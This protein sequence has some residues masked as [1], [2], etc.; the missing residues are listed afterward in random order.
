MAEALV[1]PRRFTGPV[2]EELRQQHWGQMRRTRANAVLTNQVIA[3][4]DTFVLPETFTIAGASQYIADIPQPRTVPQRALQKQ[5]A[6]RPH[7]SIPLGP[8]GLGITAQRLTTKVE[9]PLNAICEDTVAGFQWERAAALL[10]FEGFCASVTVTDPSSWQTFK[11]QW[12]DSEADDLKRQARGESDPATQKDLYDRASQASTR[13][14]NREVLRGDVFR[15]RHVPLRHRAI[16]IQQ[17]APIFGPDLSVEGLIISQEYSTSWLRRHYEFGDTGIATP[18]GNNGQDGSVSAW[19]GQTPGRT[20]TLIEG[21][22]YDED[23]IPYV[24]YCVKGQHAVEARW[25]YRGDGYDGKA[26][27]LNLKDRFGIDRLPVHWEFGLG[28]PAESNPDMRAM[29]LLE[30]FI[31]GWRSVRAKLTAN[32][33][34]ILFG[35]YPILLEEV[36]TPGAALP[37]IEEDDEPTTPDVMPLKI[38]TPRPGTTLKQLQISPVGA[39]AFEQIKLEL[40]MSAEEGPAKGD[41]TQS[42]FSQSLAAGFEELAQTTVKQ[43]LGRLYAR[44]GSYVLE[45]AKRLPELG[46]TKG[47]TRYPPIMVFDATDVPT[48]DGEDRHNEPMTLEPDLIDET[49]TCVPKYV[50]SMSIPEQQQ[51][52][53]AVA[54][55]LKTRRKHLEDMGD[56]SP[57]TTEL[58]LILES[59]RSEPAYR[60]YFLKLMAQVQGKEELEQ[61]AKG[62]QEGLADQTGM[63][64]G[65][66]QGVMPPPPMGMLPPPQEGAPGVSE[67]G[68]MTGMAPP[69]YGQSAL[70]GTVGGAGMQGPISHSLAAGGALPPTLPAPMPGAI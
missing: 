22:F 67:G 48:Q 51:S 35:S 19:A 18:T 70:A 69:Q 61:I 26:A 52:M 12:D 59:I 3:G 68:P 62:Q 53:E 34:A 28:N 36:T 60:Q 40:G 41:P 49:F 8:K 7:L 56:D 4:E 16:G 13:A 11:S 17:C 44:H 50:K 66:A 14:K 58:E 42:G 47:G 65:L 43:G 64:N 25:K 9:Q 6:S 38:T 20:L 33:V 30:P 46:E 32:N 1:S 10:L 15:A 39:E 63:A 55:N 54:R 5:I 37:S 27:T 45:A 57:E 2:L 31:G 24:S 21:W 29:G 23:G